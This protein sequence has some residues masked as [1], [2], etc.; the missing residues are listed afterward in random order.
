MKVDTFI[1]VG[2]NIHC[3]RIYKVGGLF[4]K[5]LEDGHAISY[6]SE[7]EKRF[8]PVP[9]HFTGGVMV[10]GSFIGHF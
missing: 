2:E 4:V 8:L 7:G 1:A 9:D 5:P 10:T 6:T 3:T